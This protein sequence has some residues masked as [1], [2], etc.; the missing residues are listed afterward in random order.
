[1]C[2]HFNIICREHEMRGSE[3]W[4]LCRGGGKIVKVCTQ[5][6][7]RVLEKDCWC[8][9]IYGYTAYCIR[10]RLTECGCPCCL[11]V[12]QENRSWDLKNTCLGLFCDRCFELTELFGFGSVF[13]RPVWDKTQVSGAYSCNTFSILRFSQQSTLR[14]CLLCC[15]SY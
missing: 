2:V 7:R 4:R 11:L 8:E 9:C 13:Q 1:M 3:R 6:C 15:F 10:V 14:D 5:L 12:W